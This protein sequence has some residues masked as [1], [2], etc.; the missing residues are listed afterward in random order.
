MKEGNGR[1]LTLKRPSCAK[2]TGADSNDKTRKR[3][4]GG[5]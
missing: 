4:G 3:G 2:R 1:K 5:D